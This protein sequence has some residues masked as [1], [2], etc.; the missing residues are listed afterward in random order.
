[1]FSCENQYNTKLTQIYQKCHS[2]YKAMQ[3]VCV[4]VNGADL[5]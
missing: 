1:M 5:N 2:D 3:K 4:Q